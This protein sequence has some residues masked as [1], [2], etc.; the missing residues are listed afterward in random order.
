MVM[1]YFNNKPLQHGCGDRKREKSQRHWIKGQD[2]AEIWATQ[3]KDMQEKEEQLRRML[4]KIMT[5][6][7][8]SGGE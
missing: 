4:V 7:G 3:T 2:G 6:K 1:V 5:Q 8:H